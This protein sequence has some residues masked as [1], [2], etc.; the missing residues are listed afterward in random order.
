MKRRMDKKVWVLLAG[1]GAALFL[2]SCS[3]SSSRPPTASY[4]VTI[5][6]LT[7][8]QPL[9]PAGIVLHT[10]GYMPWETGTSAGPGLEVLA[11]GGDAGEFLSEAENNTAVLEAATGNT[12]IG[13]GGSDSVEFEITAN[14]DLR[15]SFATMLVNTND[16][17]TGMGDADLSDL[18]VD[19]AVV[20]MANSYDAGTEANSESASTMPGPAAGGEGYNPAR[21]DTDI[22]VVHA[23][24]VTS[25]DGLATSALD[26]SHRWQNPVA[27]VTVT[28]IQ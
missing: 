17:F 10:S 19:E 11:E 26:E 9:S 6:N 2:T 14:A 4:R 24:V 13:P 15:V 28:R 3:D 16:A 7:Y 23:G 8:N 20:F 5:T 25:A 21:D 22:V 1:I 18:M 12:V 27:K